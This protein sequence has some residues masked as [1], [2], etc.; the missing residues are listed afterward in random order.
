MN[1]RPT[2]TA[3]ALFA[4][5]SSWPTLA[6]A[7]AYD[8]A[9]A[10]AREHEARGN[11][12]AAALELETVMGD[13]PQDFAIALEAGWLRYRA[14][15]MRAAE[16]AYR[17][18]VERAPGAPEARLGLGLSLSRQRRCDE[19]TPH[20]EVYRTARP[21]DATPAKA[22]E[23][24]KAPQAFEQPVAAQAQAAPEPKKLA[25][26]ASLT[27]GKL[28]FPSHPIK[29][30]GTS[31]AAGVGAVIDERFLLGG[32]FRYTT[33]S[34]VDG[35]GVDAFS[36]QEGYIEAGYATRKAGGT[37][38]YA[39]VTDGS[40]KLGT[41]RH[42]GATARVSVAGDLLLSLSAS[43][44]DDMSVLRVEPSWQLSLTEHLS[45][46]PGAALQVADGDLLASARLTALYR[47]GRGAL[48]LGGKVGAE[49]RPAYLSQAVVYN[50][51]EKIDWGLW[52]GGRLPLGDHLGL[53]AAYSFDRLSRTDSLSPQ[54]SNLHAL[55]L[56]VFAEF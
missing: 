19:A 37:L 43:F 5:L 32:L 52:A 34:T 26:S 16:R 38:Q 4:L 48:W 29:A 28:W 39:Q 18:A 31:V 12:V 40:G 47:M 45:V 55:T 25:L 6:S 35:S 17:V 27:G 1:H 23:G 22:L 49:Q 10:R 2:L 33:L 44:Y 20:L 54:Q 8:D 41:S 50:I 9:F 21:E 51:T 11:L 7:D 36:Q 24:C 56:G 3:A 30:G 42:L 13:Y 15:D 46:I 14:G 53:T